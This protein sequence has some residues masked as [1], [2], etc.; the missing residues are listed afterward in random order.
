MVRQKIEGLA[1]LM[2]Y[3][4]IA[5][6]VCAGN[7]DL[8]SSKSLIMAVFFLM[9]TVAIVLGGIGWTAFSWSKR[10]KTPGHE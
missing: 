10:A 7:P 2:A 1:L 3:F 4:S 6:A 5:C 9:G 8:L